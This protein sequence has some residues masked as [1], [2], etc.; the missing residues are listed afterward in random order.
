MEG[1]SGEGVRAKER[2]S[3]LD[4]AA[5]SGLPASDSKLSTTLEMVFVLKVSDRLIRLG[6]EL[7]MREILEEDRRSSVRLR[8]EMVDRLAKVLQIWVGFNQ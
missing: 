1:S 6:R 4:Q 7:M 8:E 5:A 3:S 2:D